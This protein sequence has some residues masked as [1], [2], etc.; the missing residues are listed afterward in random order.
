MVPEGVPLYS[1]FGEMHMFGAFNLFVDIPNVCWTFVY[2]FG[3]MNRLYSGYGTS[4]YKERV[5]KYLYST[6]RRVLKLA[7]F[8]S[9]IHCENRNR[10]RLQR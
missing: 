10:W 8:A 9:R 3:R 2:R 6:G 4:I 5:S 1:I 7:L